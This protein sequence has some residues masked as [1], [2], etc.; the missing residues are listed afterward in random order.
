MHWRVY[1][2]LFR[3]GISDTHTQPG[4]SEHCR[5]ELPGAQSEQAE[6]EGARPGVQDGE[7]GVEVGQVHVGEVVEGGVGKVPEIIKGECF[8]R[9]NR[10]LVQ[11]LGAKLLVAD[12]Q[13][14][15]SSVLL[16]SLLD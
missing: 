11:E 12:S 1:I 5:P 14:S 7:D 9:Q 10:G 3:G 6:D 2:F 13:H 15:L 8:Y 4:L 16:E